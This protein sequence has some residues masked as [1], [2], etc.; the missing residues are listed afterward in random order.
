MDEGAI[1]EYI[2]MT[3]PDLQHEVVQGNWF[4]FRGSERQMPVITL[5]SN[6]AFDTHSDLGRP[7]VY[8]LNIGVSGDTFAKVTAGQHDES[9]DADYTEFDR[10]LP[11]PEY[12][13]AKWV[14]VVNPGEDT[15]GEVVRPLLTEAYARGRSD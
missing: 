7:L 6:E 14:C 4:F 5:M 8:R 3:F 13:G 1:I 9:S 15:F 10:V 2:I 12:G 11:H